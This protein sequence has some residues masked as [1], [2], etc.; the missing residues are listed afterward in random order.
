MT[1]KVDWNLLKL[2]L[3]TDPEEFF[4]DFHFPR[5][6]A[7]EIDWKRMQWQLSTDPINECIDFQRK[8]WKR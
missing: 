1:D 4:P 5:P 7:G 6:P 8:T 3:S 2:Q